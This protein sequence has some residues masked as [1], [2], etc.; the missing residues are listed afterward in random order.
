MRLNFKVMN[1][2]KE[3]SSQDVELK[4]GNSIICHC[5]DGNIT[6]TI[7]KMGNTELIL[8]A[9]EPI[10]E[11]RHGCIKFSL[12]S[13]KFKINYR[14]ENR[15]AKPICDWTEMVVITPLGDVDEYK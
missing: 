4:V 3:V 9:S 14:T 7:N 8:L 1:S 6:F 12:A 2:N 10:C 13:E 15:F 11:V 5:T